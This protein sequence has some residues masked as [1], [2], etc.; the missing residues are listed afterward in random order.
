MNKRTN[1][2]LVTVCGT[3]LIGLPLFSPIATAEPMAARSSNNTVKEMCL[4]TAPRSSSAASRSTQNNSQTMTQTAASTQSEAQTTVN[5]TPRAAIRS[6]NVTLVNKTN[7]NICYQA[8]KYTA[9]RH[10]RGQSK[11]MLEDLAAPLT[12]TFYRE[13][14][15]LLQVNEKQTREGMVLTFTEARSLTADRQTLVV[16]DNGTYSIF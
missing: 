4:T 8:L 1:L 3:L 6:M 10:L 15:G 16:D 2:G 11:V 5:A 12:V 9:S 14:G 7:A 13:D